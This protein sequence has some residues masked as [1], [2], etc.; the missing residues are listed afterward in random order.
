ME[1]SQEA[2][3]VSEQRT[4][5]ITDLHG[6][7]KELEKLFN[8]M[9]FNPKHDNL[10]CLGDLMDRGPYSYE[11]YRLFRSLKDQMQ[12]RCLILMG[13]HD[14]MMLHANDN[15]VIYD[16]WMRN[17]GDLT[18]QSFSNNNADISEAYPWFQTLPLY[19]ETEQ[20][21]CAHAGLVADRPEEN[22][23]H[24]L[25]WDREMAHGRPY[26]GKLVF[27]GHTTCSNA[28]LRD[29]SGNDTALQPGKIYTLPAFG[30][31]CLDTGCV[32]GGKLTGLVLVGDQFQIHCVSCQQLNGYCED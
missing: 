22:S 19:Y 25:F 3:Y 29:K 26:H 23:P 21:I 20:F 16:R 30:Q 1:K 32:Y 7:L 10:I 18:L 11:I 9:D 14:D 15:E 17:R 27:Y 12:S 2:A 5:F 28:Y 24:D 8:L 13:N 6:C 4:L 31:I